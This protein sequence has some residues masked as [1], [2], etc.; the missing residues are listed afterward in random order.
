MDNRN[1]CCNCRKSPS[2]LH[3]IDERYKTLIQDS[4]N[5]KR[6]PF[7]EAA[8]HGQKKMIKYLLQFSNS[9]LNYNADLT[10][11]SDDSGVSFPNP[12]IIA[13]LYAN[14]FFLLPL[15]FTQLLQILF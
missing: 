15:N 10:R 8:R 1:H 2:S 7:I 14:F 11:F 12:I 4:N 3:D 5:E 9:Y 6:I 13:G